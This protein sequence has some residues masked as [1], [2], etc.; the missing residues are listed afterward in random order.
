MEF[1]QIRIEE[2]HLPHCVLAG[3]VAVD[4]FAGGMHTCA[5]IS[6]AGVMC[7][8]NNGDGQLGTGNTLNM[9]NPASEGS[10]A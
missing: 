9:L 2:R 3:A 8:G 6:G 1:P 5:S 4:V 10:G 7:W